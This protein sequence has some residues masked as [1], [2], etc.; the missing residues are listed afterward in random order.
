MFVDDT[1][2]QNQ[3]DTLNNRQDAI[4]TTLLSMDAKLTKISKSMDAFDALAQQAEQFAAMMGVG[5]PTPELSE[6]M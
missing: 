1:A 2:L 4:A 6:E 3:L 5:A